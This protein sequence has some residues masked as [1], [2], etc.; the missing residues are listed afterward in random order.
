MNSEDTIVREIRQRS[1]EI[2][3]RFGHDLRRYFRHLQQV[4]S[5]HADRVVGQLR[6]VKTDTR[7]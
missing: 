3:A 7:K 4:Q 5:R 6:V 2:S 1:L